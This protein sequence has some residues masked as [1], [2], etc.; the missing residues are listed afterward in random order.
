MGGRKQPSPVLT[1]VEMLT[2]YTTAVGLLKYE[3]PIDRLD[4]VGQHVDSGRGRWTVVR[5]TWV[6]DC[7]DTNI[8]MVFPYGGLRGR[9]L[10]HPHP[11]W[12]CWRLDRI[13]CY[14]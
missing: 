12:T 6:L 9:Q 1:G 13:R 2:G 4:L 8:E 3:S 5:G 11:Y 7:V 14:A 10:M